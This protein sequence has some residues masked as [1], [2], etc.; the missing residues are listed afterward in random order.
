[1]AAAS[2]AGSCAGTTR[3]VAFVL[4]RVLQA[5]HRRGDNGHP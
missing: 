1:M 5:V 4:D 3:P 2:A